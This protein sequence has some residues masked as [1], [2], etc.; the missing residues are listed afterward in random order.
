MGSVEV[1]GIGGRHAGRRGL[2]KNEQKQIEK[3]VKQKDSK[4]YNLNL[5]RPVKILGLRE[6]VR[7]SG[8]S[9][10]LRW[11]LDRSGRSKKR[12]YERDTPVRKVLG[13]P[14]CVFFISGNPVFL[15]FR[16]AILWGY[17]SVYWTDV[18]HSHVHIRRIYSR[19]VRTSVLLG[20]ALLA[21]PV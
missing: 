15:G 9:K 11:P 2:K 1:R 18:T 12:L 14:R 19:H 8:Q 3:N 21:H 7:I 10:F 4:L 5:F 20:E 17:Y 16:R 6:N 13:K